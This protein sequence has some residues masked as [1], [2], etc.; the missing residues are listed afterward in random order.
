M[1][2]EQAVSVTRK[3]YKIFKQLQDLTMK[4]LEEDTTDE[5]FLALCVATEA[6]KAVQLE[7]L[8]QEWEESITLIARGLLQDVKGLVSKVKA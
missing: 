1:T 4:I 6:V 2:H 3:T 5:A 8:P 7:T